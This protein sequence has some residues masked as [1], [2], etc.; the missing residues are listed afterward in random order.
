M[1]RS[2]ALKTQ[3]GKNMIEGKKK[4]KGVKILEIV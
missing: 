3:T 4:M 2:V 1:F